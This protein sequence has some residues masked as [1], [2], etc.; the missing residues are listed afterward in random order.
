MNPNILPSKRAPLV[1]VINPVSDDAGDSSTGWVSMAD[2][3]NIMAVIAAGAITST[4]VLNAKLEQAQNSGGTGVKNITGKAITP[5]TQAGSDSNKQAII[6]CRSDE[7]DMANGFTHV[8]LTITPSV[9]A[10]VFVG[11]IF[12]FDARFQ[13]ADDLTSVDEVIGNV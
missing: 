5:L 13:P 10:T 6:N 11:L 1:G 3:D 2:F 9:A 8:R 7:L 12:G 4:G